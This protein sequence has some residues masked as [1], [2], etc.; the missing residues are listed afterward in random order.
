MSIVFVQQ[1]QRIV[2]A[3]LFTLACLVCR[4]IWVVSVVNKRSHLKYTES[5]LHLFCFC[6]TQGKPVTVNLVLRIKS[7]P[8]IISHRYYFTALN[9]SGEN[10]LHSEGRISHHS[11]TSLICHDFCLATSLV[12]LCISLKCSVKYY[13]WYT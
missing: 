10:I 2:G 4:A 8:L 5:L 12:N 6:S 9:Y 13:T 1:E 3:I 7:T 11:T